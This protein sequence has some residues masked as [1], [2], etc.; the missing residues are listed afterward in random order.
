MKTGFQS[1]YAQ[2][3]QFQLINKS[4]LQS[5]CQNYLRKYF[6]LFYYIL[7]MNYLLNLRFQI[8]QSLL[9]IKQYLEFKSEFKVYQV[10]RFPLNQAMSSLYYFSFTDHSLTNICSSSFQLFS[11]VSISCQC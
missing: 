3:S 6:V 5:V 10:F 4:N 8:G 9:I 2:C 11:Y 7:I 1:I